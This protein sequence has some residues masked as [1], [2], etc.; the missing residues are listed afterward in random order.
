MRSN[1]EIINLLE[2]SKSQKD[3]SISEIARQVG[4]AKSAVSRYFNRTR[5]F[6]LNR[7]EDFA[8]VFHVKP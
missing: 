2:Q 7:V 8:K 4:M 6:P 3:L 5:Q 1:D